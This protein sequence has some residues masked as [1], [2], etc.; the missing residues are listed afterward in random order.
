MNKVELRNDLAISLITLNDTDIFTS[1]MGYSQGE[2]RVLLYLDMHD[3]DE[4]YPSDL[5]DELHV[6]R[7]RITSILSSLRKKGYVSMKTA[8]NDRRK[9]QV[10]LTEDA[11]KYVLTKGTWIE[12]YFDNL[13]EKFGEENALEL[14]RLINLF[15]EQLKQNSSM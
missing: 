3:G 10:V 13:L 5:S 6:T 11:K 15:T 1:M 2:K 4:I 8:A 14:T 12:N 7:Q 9:K